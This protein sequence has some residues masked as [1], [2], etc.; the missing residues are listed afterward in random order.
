MI[1]CHGHLLKFQTLRLF[2]SAVRSEE[3][4]SAKADSDVA[5][6]DYA[7]KGEPSDTR[8]ASFHE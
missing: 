7:S 6:D 2:F 8:L 1:S 4:T 5:S 3:E